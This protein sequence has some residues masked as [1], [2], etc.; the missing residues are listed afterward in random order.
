MLAF[1]LFV[2]LCLL[3]GGVECRDVDKHMFTS[4]ANLLKLYFMEEEGLSNVDLYLREELLQHQD[5]ASVDDAHN[6]SSVRKLVEEAK[7][8]HLEVGSEVKEYLS[9]PINAFHL[10][11][12][13]HYGWREAIQLIKNSKACREWHL[14]QVVARL[15]NIEE[16]LP[17]SEDMSAVAYNLFT[18]Q[19][20][21][22]VPT[23][24]LLKG[25]LGQH[26]SRAPISPQEQFRIVKLAVEEDEYYYAV[27]WLKHLSKSPH[28]KDMRREEDGFNATNVL[29]MLASAYFRLKMTPEALKATEELL[30]KD[31]E[32]TL[33]RSNKAFFQE[34][35]TRDKEKGDQPA[36]V[37]RYSNDDSYRK[38]FETLCRGTK[39]KLRRLK[40]RLEPTWPMSKISFYK[41]EVLKRKPPIIA[42]HDVISRADATLIANV[43]DKE[44]EKAAMDTEEGFKTPAFTLVLSRVKPADKKRKTKLLH[45]KYMDTLSKISDRLSVLPHMA[46]KPFSAGEFEA[47][48]FG[49]QGFYLKPKSDFEVYT[50]GGH[51]GTAM[52]FLNDVKMG[53]EIV[54]PSAK[55]RVEPRVGTVVYYYPSMKRF[56]TVCPV[57]YGTEWLLVR[58][59][60]ERR[61]YSWCRSHEDPDLL[62]R[63]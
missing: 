27:Q 35:V 6:L 42:I 55:T 49:H 62:R 63:K 40:C 30:K 4:Y 34:R 28:L 9:H 59:F 15:S 3:Q 44:F 8:T 7:K 23:S 31:P 20:T 24:H 50:I 39:L 25:L 13:L 10:A 52:M 1:V 2:A 36:R 14:P 12:R 21:Q 16:N 53:G 51:T 61:A 60:F 47:R 58:S 37:A 19:Y 48:N 45:E 43:S 5:E 29:G 46:L 26:A 57:A 33:A 18:I 32:N 54:F 17:S 38:N 41:V 11:Q 56:H 22:K